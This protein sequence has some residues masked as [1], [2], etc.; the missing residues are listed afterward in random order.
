VAL[1]SRVGELRE[2]LRVAQAEV[3]GKENLRP[4]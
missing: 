1:E 3:T 2:Q 4:R